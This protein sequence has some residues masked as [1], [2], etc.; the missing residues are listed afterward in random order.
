MLIPRAVLQKLGRRSYI[1][2][3]VTSRSLFAFHSGRASRPY[4]AA[5]LD[6]LLYLIG[7]S[8]AEKIFGVDLQ[9]E[10]P[11][12]PGWPTLLTRAARFMSLSKANQPP[13]V[14]NNKK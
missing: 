9:E 12:E 4:A 13:K 11:H 5:R 2:Q 7:A 14:K 10:A 6:A 1:S 8:G 3:R